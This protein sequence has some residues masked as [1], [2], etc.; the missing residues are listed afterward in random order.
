MMRRMTTK[1]QRHALSVLS[2]EHFNA[3]MMLLDAICYGGQ[4]EEFRDTKKYIERVIEAFPAD[5]RKTYDALRKEKADKLRQE[6][7]AIERGEVKP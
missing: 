5:I 1:E 2:R 6:A 7:D 4:L 3:D